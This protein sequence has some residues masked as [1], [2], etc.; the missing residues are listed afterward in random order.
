MH[1]ADYLKQVNKT[2]EDMRKEWGPDAEKRSKLQLVLAE[3]A[4]KEAIKPDPAK[5]DR[6]VAHIK[7]HYPDA[8]TAAIRAYTTSQMTNNLV[9]AYLEGRNV[10]DVEVEEGGHDHNHAH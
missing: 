8:D 7:E 2:V 10:E 5:L 6:E 3:I 4:K 1:M 9:F